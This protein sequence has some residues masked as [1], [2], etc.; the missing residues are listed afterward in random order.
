MHNSPTKASA[1]KT[2]SDFGSDDDYGRYIKSQ[3]VVGTT[4]VRIVRDPPSHANIGDEPVYDRD[5]GSLSPSF[6]FPDGHTGYVSCHKLEIV[7]PAGAAGPVA[8]GPL[9]VKLVAC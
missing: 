8:T 2:R 6:R 1:F 5:D 7:A 4:K 3:M 9:E